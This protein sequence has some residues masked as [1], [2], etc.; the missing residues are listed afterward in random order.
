M[1]IGEKVRVAEGPFLGMYG[2]IISSLRRRVVV[3][4]AL[5]SREVEVEIERDWIVGTT[6]L[7]RGTSHIE[8][9]KRAAS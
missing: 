9:P 8:N 7:R 4:V 5:E 6:P 2:A 1:R 3:A